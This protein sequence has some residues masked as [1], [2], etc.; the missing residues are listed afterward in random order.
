MLK[1]VITN[2]MQNKIKR[3]L[4]IVL[5]GTLMTT[6]MAGC[7]E[8]SNA[9]YTAKNIL[10]ASDYNVTQ[11]VK[12][13]DLNNI[14]VSEIEKPE[15]VTDDDVN[16]YEDYL[17]QAYP[18]Y[19]AVD[20]ETVQDG[21]YVN[22]DYIGKIDGEEFE[23]GTVEDT[24]LEIGSGQFIEGFEEGL[25]DHKSGEKVTLNLT[26]PDDY[27][28]EYA[29]K[30]VVFDIRINGIYLAEFYTHKTITDEFCSNN[31]GYDTTEEYASSLKDTL[32]ERI[33]QNYEYELQSTV[34]EQ[35]IEGSEINIP[36]DKVKKQV[37]STKDECN[38][39]AEEAG[40]TA[41][42][43]C[44]ESNGYDTLDAYMES[45]EE[46][47]RNQLKQDYVM[48]AVMLQLN[49]TYT[50][51]EFDKFVDTYKKYYGASGE[52]DLYD[53]F[54][55]KEKTLI[56]FGETTTLHHLAKS[57]AEKISSSP[58]NQESSGSAAS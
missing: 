52:E 12:L 56:A 26:F 57:L 23:G 36:D 33:Q 8:N 38:S 45:V 50:K 24:Y 3:V 41:D 43:Y 48:Q 20:H 40:M 31:F 58:G 21:D 9:Y 25:K 53:M 37:D 35:L 2:C 15:T 13:C 49:D 29:N 55:S 11:N 30:D 1:G 17:L 4:S 18:N 6:G 46:S 42:E 22:I 39:A 34:L 14:D 5:A 51:E 32:E 19:K 16:Q 10:K 54:G 47:I 7:G 44:Q 28:E 27:D